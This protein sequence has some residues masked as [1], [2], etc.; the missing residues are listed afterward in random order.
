M[1]GSLKP[2]R[3]RCPRG[4]R[5]IHERFAATGDGRLR[6]INTFGG[7]PAGCAVALRTM[8]IM[9]GEDL[10]GRAAGSALP[11]RLA[12][13]LALPGVGDV[14]GLG[15]LAG[16]ELVEDRASRRPVAAGVARRVVEACRERGVI[17][18]M[19]ANTAAGLSNVVMAGPPLVAG[20]DELDLLATTLE[21][22]IKE[23]L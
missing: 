17:V 21:Q 2:G 3:S 15:L 4:R 7:H 1:R 6:H 10:P 14:R 22:A 5:S 20:E 18:G 13:L 9:D 8:D 23:V 16:V 19:N 11:R 12:P